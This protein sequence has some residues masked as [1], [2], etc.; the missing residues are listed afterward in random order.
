M[1]RVQGFDGAADVAALD[2]GSFGKATTDL[3]FL[4]KSGKKSKKVGTIALRPYA[5]TRIAATKV[6][7]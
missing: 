7:L 6:P 1:V 3:A 5:V 2:E 4:A